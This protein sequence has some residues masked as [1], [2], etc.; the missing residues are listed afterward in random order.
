MVLQAKEHLMHYLKCSQMWL[1]H[2]LQ[3]W[4]TWPLSRLV[5]M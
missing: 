1:P 4:A 3:D 2:A 5:L